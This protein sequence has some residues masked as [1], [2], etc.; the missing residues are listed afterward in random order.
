[1]ARID[2]GMYGLPQARILAKKLLKE[3][4]E[5]HGYQECEH[6]PGLWRHNT[7]A[8]MFSLVVDDFGIQYTPTECTAPVSSSQTAL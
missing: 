6:T 8:L 7:R 1:M 3:R 4:L 2:K 5:P